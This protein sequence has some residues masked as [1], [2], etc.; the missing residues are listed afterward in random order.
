MPNKNPVYPA[1]PVAPLLMSPISPSV[2]IPE[3][4]GRRGNICLLQANLCPEI[5]FVGRAA[6]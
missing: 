6:E 2:I 4:A 1:L 3:R 5:T